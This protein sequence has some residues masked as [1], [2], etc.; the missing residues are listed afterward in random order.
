MP[1]EQQPKSG[2]LTRRNLFAGG[3]ASSLLHAVPTPRSINR[4]TN[5]TNAGIVAGSPGTLPTG[6]TGG[7]IIG[8]TQ[9]ISAVG[10]T[11]KGL[12]TFNLRLNGTTNAQFGSQNINQFITSYVGARFTISGYLALAAGTTT[13]VGTINFNIADFTVASGFLGESI[14]TANLVG[15]IT[16]TL[17]RFSASG[18]VGFAGSV[19]GLPN[20]SIIASAASG[21][22]VDITLQI[23]GVMVQAGPVLTKWVP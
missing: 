18:V 17:T 11:S 16:A 21:Q 5:A 13:N 15:S 20:I 14:Q 1:W 8:L 2:L 4:L 3:A 12:P 6:W 22:A 19:F 7:S 9:T 23:A 10:Y